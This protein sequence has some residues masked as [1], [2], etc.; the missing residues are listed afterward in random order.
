MKFALFFLL[1]STTAHALECGDIPE[2]TVVRIDKGNGSLAKASVQDQD[3]V[4]SCF[5]NQASLLLQ[6]ILPNNPNLS[7]LNLALI[8]T[9]DYKMDKFKNEGKIWGGFVCETISSAIK[10]QKEKGAGVLCKTEDVNLEHSMMNESNHMED[11]QQNQNK[12]L[13]KTWKYVD[14]YQKSFGVN[15]KTRDQ[16]DLFSKNL[17]AFVKDSGETYSNKECEKI[18]S[19]AIENVMNSMILKALVTNDCLGKNNAILDK[20][21]ICKTISSI[22]YVEELNPEKK[23]NKIAFRVSG[24][25]LIDVYSPTEKKMVQLEKNYKRDFSKSI[26]QIFKGKNI[27]EEFSKVFTKFFTD[28]A[29]WV[30]QADAKRK[31]A[32]SILTNFSP[33]DKTNLDKEYKRVALKETAD[34]KAKIA[35]NF[36]KDKKQFL[37]NAKN[38]TALCQYSELLEGAFDLAGVLPAKQFNNVSSF[39]DF[40]TNKAGLPYDQAIT[41]FL[42]SDCTP[43]KR[44]RLPETLTC[45]RQAI[46]FD[47]KSFSG[48]STSPNAR[49]KISLNRKKMFDHISKGRGV[50]I[51]LCT[52]VWKEPSYEFQNVPYK[53]RNEDC[54][55]SGV[56]GLHAITMI[57]YRCKNK[58]LEYLSQ[59]SW[60]P[61]WQTKDNAF[62]V[63]DGKIW[64]DEDTLFRNMEGINYI[65][66]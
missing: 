50:G 56:H 24:K 52:K 16:A 54:M 5:A 36:F 8:Y 22:G 19:E 17:L 43:E 14:T 40:I 60:G 41:S 11:P 63:E 25:S 4:G 47:E 28:N 44:I 37:E 12:I 21:D 13:Q 3:G 57:G 30:N 10:H 35:L 18:D 59:N 26:P 1:A 51:D 49:E 27:K 33:E 2:G 66:P 31:I 53:T 64:M 29:R 32:A 61:N 62:E 65:T 7:Y 9:A 20:K 42:A 23:N 55:K 38:N 45:E 15:P 39:L 48:N 46:L 34:C 58:K 6:S